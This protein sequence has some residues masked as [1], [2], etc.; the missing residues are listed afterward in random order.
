MSPPLLDSLK[1]NAK[2]NQRRHALHT[3]V[4]MPGLITSTKDLYICVEEV[5]KP[6]FVSGKSLTADIIEIAGN[7]NKN[8]SGHLILIES[9]DPGY[10][11]LFAHNIAGLITK[12]GGVA[13]H[14]A[15][16]CSEFHLPAVIGC[17]ELL[18]DRL[19]SAKRVYLDCATQK[20]EILCE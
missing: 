10:D 16:R 9:A 20:I 13:S 1:H 11:W 2:L 18:Y 14:M 7:T 19:K 12:Y 3:S 4:R 8:L 17:G 5:A 6:N 15:I